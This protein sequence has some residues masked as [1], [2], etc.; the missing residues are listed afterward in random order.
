MI[1]SHVHFWDPSRLQ[2]SWLEALP[3][4]NHACLPG[5]YAYHSAMAS[6]NKMIFV[7]CGCSTGESLQEVAWVSEL[8]VNERRL[9]G[10]VARAS[11]E[12]GTRVR[13]E[14]SALAKYPLVKG[15]RR[16]FEDEVQDFCLQPEFISGVRELAHFNFSMDICIR[17]N[18]LPAVVKLVR[19]CPEINF[20]LDH[21]GKP[22]IRNRIR[23]PWRQHIASLSKEQN[24]Y[25]KISGLMTEAQYKQWAPE[26]FLPYITH[27]LECFG[28]DRVMLGGDWPINT[29]SGTYA[30][31]SSIVAYC[32]D[33]LDDATRTK[34]YSTTAE[35]F[36]RL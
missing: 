7:E 23:D 12:Q 15:V 21:C 10:I 35:S 20:V 25:C 8:A 33:D 11:L 27:V 9:C 2:Y 22:D 3:S 28:P 19:E 4:L 18:Q 1:D 6:I 29:L 36:Y 14:L 17:H 26:H 16:N 24:V 34:V 30:E 32:L 31:W 5:D 13:A